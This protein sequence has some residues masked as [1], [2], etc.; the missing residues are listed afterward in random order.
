MRKR[1]DQY[2]NTPYGGHH[3]QEP[4]RDIVNYAKERFITIIPEV[5]LPGHMVA[6]LASYP[7]LGCTGGADA[8]SAKECG[9]GL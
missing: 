1:F 7:S 9:R 8:G 2:D 3:T 5:D 6:A 4:I